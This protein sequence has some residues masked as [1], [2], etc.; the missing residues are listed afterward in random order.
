MA[1][2][3]LA[4][5]LIERVRIRCG[6][7]V[8]TSETNITTA[9]ILSIVQESARELSALMNEQDWYFV[10]T[11]TL[12]TVANVPYV[13]LPTNFAALQRLSW[14]R[15]PSQVIPL[16]PANLEDVHP[17]Q[18]PD[19]W[20][21]RTP[22]YRISGN[23]LEFFPTPDAVYALELRY[24]TGAFLAS[25]GD[26]LFGQIGWDTWVVYN[27]C[28]VVCQVQD[29]EYARFADERDRKL[30]EIMR[31]ARRDKTGVVQPRDVRGVAQDWDPAGNWWRL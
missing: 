11:S 24:S 21:S 18:T 16:D 12:A 19:T 13:S 29:K 23:T 7:P 5:E 4:S 3:F 14:L 26:T 8:Y 6:L 9:A 20:T 10:S 31:S 22:E 2:G 30:T 28:C 1:V 25:A 27:A 15:L 17:T